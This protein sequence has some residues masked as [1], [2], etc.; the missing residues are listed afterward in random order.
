MSDGKR[1][2]SVDG[3]TVSITSE[4]H[5]SSGRASDDPFS[6]HA[7][8]STSSAPNP[9][10]DP[11][12]ASIA[13]SSPASTSPGSRQGGTD[14][15]TH[16]GS[17]DTRQSAGEPV[18]REAPENTEQTSGDT[19]GEESTTKLH[20][21]LT[22]QVLTIM[23]TPASAQTLRLYAKNAEVNPRPHRRAVYAMMTR[24]VTGTGSKS[25]EEAIAV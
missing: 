7:R 17:L 20:L 11:R 1:K 5:I 18:S 10:Q 16:P 8:F 15:A 9:F 13:S 4:S 6:N 12:K 3:S 25:T 2:S 22:N 19:A 24:K 14:L 21:D 23:T